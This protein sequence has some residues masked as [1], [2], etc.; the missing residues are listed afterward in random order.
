MNATKGKFS[1]PSLSLYNIT[2]SFLFYTP[3]IPASVLQPWTWTWTCAATSLFVFFMVSFVFVC[4]C[5][6]LCLCQSRFF[7]LRPSIPARIRFRWANFISVMPLVCNS[8]FGFTGKWPPLFIEDLFIWT[9][10][11]L[12]PNP[13]ITW[14]R[15]LRWCCL[16]RGAMLYCD[17][18]LQE[19]HVCPVVIVLN[20]L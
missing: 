7:A 6:S 19:S 3:V 17:K 14:G 1:L 18:R 10:W 4:V 15:R 9:S 13:E 12:C 5:P 11:L 2:C 16:W 8:Q 20:W